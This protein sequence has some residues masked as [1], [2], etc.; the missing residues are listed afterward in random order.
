MIS[1]LPYEKFYIR[2]TKHHYSNMFADKELTLSA[3]FENVYGFN[4]TI[5]VKVRWVKRLALKIHPEK[6]PI[7]LEQQ[8]SV[9]AIRRVGFNAT[10]KELL[11]TEFNI[12][13]AWIADSIYKEN[14]KKTMDL[15]FD[16]SAKKFFTQVLTRYG[17]HKVQS[18]L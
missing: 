2:L 7:D 3:F 13:S 12:W 17:E 15:S 9:A 8:V 16:D 6:D 18:K 5:D 14:G 4:P 11:E 1:L 10:V